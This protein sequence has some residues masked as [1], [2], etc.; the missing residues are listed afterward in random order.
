APAQLPIGL[1]LPHDFVREVPGEKER[2]VGAI[3]D[4]ARRGAD[5]KVG[6]RREASLLHRRAIDH[7]VEKPPVDAEAVEQGRAFRRGAICDDPL[8]VTFKLFQE[9]AERGAQR[10]DAITEA[11]V[12]PEVI[13]APPPLLVEQRLY[14][15]PS[16]SV[17]TARRGDAQ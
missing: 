13:E 10:R 4:E 1:L 16:R 2:K 17:G 9:R 6:S 5:Q 14:P 8:A 15:L 7:V 3:F 11:S 12:K